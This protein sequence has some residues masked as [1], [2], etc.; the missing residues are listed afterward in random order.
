[1][2]SRR[3]TKL[4][5]CV[6]AASMCAVPVYATTDTTVIAEDNGEGQVDLTFGKEDVTVRVSVPTSAA[7]KVNP[8]YNTSATGTVSG[9][10]VASRDL[11]ILNKTFTH[12][13]STTS[14]NTGVSIN[15]TAQAQITGKA[16]GVKAYYGQGTVADTFSA[17]SEE[18]NIQMQL[19]S[20]SLSDPSGNATYTSGQSA[21]VTELGSRI[22]FSVSGPS[23]VSDGNDADAIDVSDNQ[24]GL[25]AMAILGNATVNAAWVTED[26][27][28]GLIYN[29]KASNTPASEPAAPSISLTTSSKVIM[30]T[31]AQLAGSNVERVSLQDPVKNAYGLFDVEFGEDQIE[32]D[33]SGSLKL[34]VDDGIFSFLSGETELKG[35]PQDLLVKMEDGRVFVGTLTA[36]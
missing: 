3:V 5:A 13:Q 17:D 12:D 34:T 16:E 32:T 35:K 11:R 36:N 23:S 24:A 21:Y 9:S 19:K 8:F 20:G 7:L 30:I 29:I 25:G 27:S 31:Q 6:L 28:V 26:L 14:G 22:K 10:Q 1:M 2:K 18:K 4:L 15:V 33:A